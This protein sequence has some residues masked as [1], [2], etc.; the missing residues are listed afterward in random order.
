M[1]EDQSAHFGLLRIFYSSVRRSCARIQLR[2]L[3]EWLCQGM[4]KNKKDQPNGNFRA[5]LWDCLG[6]NVR[7][8]RVRK[9]LR[10][11]DM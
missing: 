5:D 1:T 3:G 7:Q 9:V 11:V 10:W 6:S 4:Q 8:K 2:R